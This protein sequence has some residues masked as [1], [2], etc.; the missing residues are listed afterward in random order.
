MDDFRVG[1]GYIHVTDPRLPHDVINKGV[2]I[3]E[4]SC[5]GKF[6]I[7]AVNG[8]WLVRM[9]SKEFIQSGITFFRVTEMVALHLVRGMNVAFHE[10]LQRQ[11]FFNG[12]ESGQM[13]IFDSQL[14]SPGQHADSRRGLYNQCRAAINDDLGWGILDDRGVVASTGG[15]DGTFRTIITYGPRNRAVGVRILFGLPSESSDPK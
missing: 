13:G 11:E 14:L 15:G 1:S 3:G 9:T 7:P 6:D 5:A 8:L 10:R 12:V 4:K 2:R